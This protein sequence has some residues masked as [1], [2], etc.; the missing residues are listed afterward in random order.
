MSQQIVRGRLA[1]PARETTQRDLIRALLFVQY[2]LFSLVVGVQGVLWGEVQLALRLGDGPFGTAMALTPLTGFCVLVLAGSRLARLDQRGLAVAGLLGVGAALLALGALPGVSGLVLARL[3]AGLGFA[4]LESSATT[5]A[6]AWEERTSGGLVGPLYGLFSGGMVAGSLLGSALLGAG[7]PYRS[8]LLMLAPGALLVALATSLVAYPR[9]RAGAVTT[10][11]A[12]TA[13][14]LLR[15]RA[16]LAL[17]ALCLIGVAGEALADLWAVIY[18]RARGADQLVS[19]AGF[20]LFNAAMIAG[21][22]ASGR[23]RA[24]LGDRGVLRLACVGVAFA[25]GLLA[26]GNMAASVAAFGLLGL[27]VAGVVPM[28]L[29]AARAERAGGAAAV[30][31]LVAT[32]YL[33]F[34]LTPPLIG[35]IAEWG[36][37]HLTLLLCIGLI[38]AGLATLSRTMPGAPAGRLERSRR[39]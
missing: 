38:G 31:G 18:L 33:G 1:Q 28:T 25:G 35:W 14:G 7:L 21:R 15:N 30:N 26:L 11:P 23:M 8:I 20:A 17:A 5:S 32:T 29:G 22:F 19:G 16:F 13:R 12:H 24:R 10:A 36:G 4:L 6:V 27:A 37:L 34:V 9:P 39:R 3:L 2:L